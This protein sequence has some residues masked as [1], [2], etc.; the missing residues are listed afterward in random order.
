MTQQCLLLLIPFLGRLGEVW[1]KEWLI[2]LT[3]KLHHVVQ[4]KLKQNVNQLWPEIKIHQ[5]KQILRMILRPKMNLCILKQATAINWERKDHLV[6]SIQCN[7]HVLVN[8]NVLRKST[9]KNKKQYI[10]NI[11]P[12][13]RKIKKSFS[14]TES[15]GFLKKGQELD[16]FKL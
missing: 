10:C 8:K 13:R 12:W 6:I 3:I 1:I 14:F 9:K 15:S 2:S 11:V 5:T 7:L 4:M 16:A